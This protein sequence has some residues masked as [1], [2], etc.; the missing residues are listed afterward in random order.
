MKKFLRKIIRVLRKIDDRVLALSRWLENLGNRMI[1]WSER[2][3][4]K[5]NERLQ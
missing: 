3:Q 2:Q 1:A 5:L 4:A